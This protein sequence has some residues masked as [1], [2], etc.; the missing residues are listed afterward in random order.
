MRQDVVVFGATGKV[1]KT[2]INQILDKDIDK[3]KITGVASSKN[4]IYD[5]GGLAPET[6]KDFSKGVLAGDKYDGEH[7]FVL[8]RVRMLQ[9]SPTSFVDVT[10]S[11]EMTPTHL[12]VVRDPFYGGM[13]TANKNPLVGDFKD[14][15]ELTANNGKYQFQCSVMA[16]AGAI[17]EVD[18]FYELGEKV[19]NIIGCFSGTLSYLCYRMRN[20]APFSKALFEARSRKKG[21]TE[22]D[23]RPDLLGGDV[24]KKLVIL[25]RRSGK[26]V[27]LEDIIIDPFLPKE[28][29]VEGEG[30]RSFRR[31]VKKGEYDEYFDERIKS[32]ERHGSTIQ[33][34]ARMWTPTVGDLIRE[35]ANHFPKLKTKFRVG[36]E[37]VPKSDLM[38][39]LKG[40]LNGFRIVTKEMYPEETPSTITAAGAGLPVTAGNVRAGLNDLIEK[41]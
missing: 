9:E 38:A 1:G 29:F 35:G 33:Y 34:V 18:K 11:T 3:R 19:K 13:V 4:W 36:L 30:I 23:E 7:D 5:E 8:D 14:F 15:E 40:T 2:L 17:K 6:I 32:A 41:G 39:G 16:G 37:E 28:A 22:P 24:G 25:G 21:Y 27:N 31:R 12:R 10:A 20:D 26:E